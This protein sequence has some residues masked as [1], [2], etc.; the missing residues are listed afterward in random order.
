MI[1]NFSA[2]GWEAELN[3]TPLWPEASQMHCCHCTDSETEAGSSRA[4]KSSL[5][6]WP[7]ELSLWLL[8]ARFSVP[9]ERLA[10]CLAGTLRERGINLIISL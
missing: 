8:L 4:P 10:S 9:S 5:V 1:G 3:Q 6:A 7:R 2:E